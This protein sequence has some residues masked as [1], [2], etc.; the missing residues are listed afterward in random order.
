MPICS[1]MFLKN[2]I[3]RL[4][5]KT[6]LTVS[7][8]IA[9]HTLHV[10][11]PNS[12]HL[13]ILTY[14]QLSCKSMV[15]ATHN[16]PLLASGR[17]PKCPLP[18]KGCMHRL[19]RAHS[20]SFAI[21]ASKRTGSCPFYNLKNRGK[22]QKISKELHQKNATSSNPELSRRQLTHTLA[23]KHLIELLMWNA[24]YVQKHFS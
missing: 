19:M 24:S 1:N 13:T 12:F 2:H 21:N 10:A 6:C 3:F 17:K 14:L 18:P 23:Q 9:K 20:I 5:W 4:S 11:S 16:E 8:T 15:F 7:G 22:Q